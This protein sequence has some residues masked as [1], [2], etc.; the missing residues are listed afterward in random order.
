MEKRLEQ[1]LKR[2]FWIVGWGLLLVI[3]FGLVATVKTLIAS[4][5]A[6]LSNH[7]FKLVSGLRMLF[8]GLAQAF[9]AFMMSSI[10]GMMF[11]GRPIHRER[12]D[13]F[14]ILTCLGFVGEGVI[15][16]I[17]WVQLL[18]TQLP[19]SDWLVETS[20]FFGGL[21]SLAPFLYAVSIY[22][23]YRHY[24]KLITFESEVI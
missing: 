14:M 18:I 9:F 20:Y 4:P 6:E 21:S 13:R 7:S 11:H 16:I 15:G 8:S 3:V 22:L 12:T 5:D 19:H 24:S 17:S 1:N 23:L 2:L 10:F